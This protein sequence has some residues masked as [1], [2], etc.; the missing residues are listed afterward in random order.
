MV[1][2]VGGL[3]WG[4]EGGLLLSWVVRRFLLEVEGPSHALSPR[5][6]ESSGVGR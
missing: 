4:R 2:L 3:F 5:T 6:L 1:G